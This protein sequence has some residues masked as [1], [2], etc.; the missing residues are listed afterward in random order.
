LITKIFPALILSI[1]SIFTMYN[2]EITS[3]I[4]VGILNFLIAKIIVEAVYDSLNNNKK[5]M[6]KK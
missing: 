5:K 1:V 2:P 6:R 3:Y 4:I